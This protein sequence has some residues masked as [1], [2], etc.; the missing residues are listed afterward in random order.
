MDNWRK[1]NLDRILNHAQK[2]VADKCYDAL[3][4]VIAGIISRDPTRE[5]KARE[6]LELSFKALGMATDLG[7]KLKDVPEA[8]TSATAVKLKQVSVDEADIQKQ[9]LEELSNVPDA[10]VK[11]WYNTNRGRI[12]Q[13]KAPEYRNPLFDSIRTRLR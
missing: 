5:K 9:L 7:G 13:V 4:E 12:E 6:A 11:G 8:S 1:E 2:E 3:G 10:G